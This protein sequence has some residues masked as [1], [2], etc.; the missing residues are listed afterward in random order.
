MQKK[1]EIKKWFV[2]TQR[3]VMIWQPSLNF[4]SGSNYLSLDNRPWKHVGGHQVRI[5]FSLAIAEPQV[6]LSWHLC[7]TFACLGYPY[8][9]GDDSSRNVWNDALFAAYVCDTNE[10]I[11]RQIQKTLHRNGTKGIDPTLYLIVYLGPSY[12][13]A[14]LYVCTV[15][16][17]ILKMPHFGLP[18]LLTNLRWCSTSPAALCCLKIGDKGTVLILQY[19]VNCYTEYC[20]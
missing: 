20:E 15:D 1:R 3:A 9:G 5:V 11:C 19:T 7:L 18:S 8:A 16:V 4:R 2:E 14:V 13:A 10:T 17:H 12:D 6:S